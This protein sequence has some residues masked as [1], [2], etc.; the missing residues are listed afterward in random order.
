MIGNDAERSPR[1]GGLVTQTR[2]PAAV[3]TKI[4]IL[5]RRIKGSL[6]MGHG[7]ARGRRNFPQHSY[8]M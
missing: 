5:R 6:D 8:Y 7:E 1:T 2:F 4:T 3:K